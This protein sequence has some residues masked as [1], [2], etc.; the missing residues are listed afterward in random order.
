MVD[1]R[2]HQVGLTL[3]NQRRCPTSGLA[4]CGDVLVGV[5]AVFDWPL[6]RG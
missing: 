4:R 3:H 1:E 2:V 5:V 6:P